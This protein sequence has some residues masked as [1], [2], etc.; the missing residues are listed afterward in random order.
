MKWMKFVLC[1]TYPREKL[2][3]L[4]LLAQEISSKLAVKRPLDYC[5]PTSATYSIFTLIPLYLIFFKFVISGKHFFV[6]VGYFLWNSHFLS[7]RILSHKVIW[8][9]LVRS[10]INCKFMVTLSLPFLHSWRLQ[11]E[12]SVSSEMLTVFVS[13]I[14]CNLIGSQDGLLL[15]RKL[16]QLLDSVLG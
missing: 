5:Q 1:F 10:F 7:G 6:W 9:L 2:C 8:R 16:V 3:H 12:I 4:F 14:S 11:V 15:Q 13:T